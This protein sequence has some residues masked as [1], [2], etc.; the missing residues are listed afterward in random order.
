MGCFIL[1][2]ETSPSRLVPGL[3]ME[4]RHIK[5]NRKQETN[6]RGILAAGDCTGKPYQVAKSIGEGQVA[7][8]QANLLASQIRP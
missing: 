1:G 6:L 3:E 7:G 5:V 2:G 4:D 8:L